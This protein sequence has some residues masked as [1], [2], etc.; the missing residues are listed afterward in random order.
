MILTPQ[1]TFSSKS[2]KLKCSD[3]LQLEGTRTATLDLKL[4]DEDETKLAW[5]LVTS[6]D[7]VL[8]VQ[9]ILVDM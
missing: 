6:D 4:N 1:S 9:L 3:S 8:L 7:E 5:S 2:A